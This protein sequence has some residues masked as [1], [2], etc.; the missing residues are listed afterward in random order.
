MQSAA[1]TGDGLQRDNISLLDSFGAA[2]AGSFM[3]VLLCA[4]IAMKKGKKRPRPSSAEYPSPKKTAAMLEVSRGNTDLGYVECL[5]DEE[6]AAMMMPEEMARRL[7]QSGCLTFC[8]GEGASKAATPHRN[9]CRRSPPPSSPPPP[10]PLPPTVA[11][12]AAAADRRCRRSP[13]PPLLP[14]PT[15]AAAAPHRYRRCRSN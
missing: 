9:S 12:T 3:A 1:A 11:T 14:Q 6:T 13:P 10:P 4:M 5:P 2:T 15:V 7:E 8:A